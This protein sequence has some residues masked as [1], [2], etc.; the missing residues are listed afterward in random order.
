MGP[1]VMP[2]V[3]YVPVSF[4]PYSNKFNILCK[5][6]VHLQYCWQIKCFTTNHLCPYGTIM[7]Y[8]LVVKKLLL[9]FVTL[10]P[11]ILICIENMNHT[12]LTTLLRV[13]VRCT[14][15]SRG[16]PCRILSIRTC[17]WID[18]R[19]FTFLFFIYQNFIILLKIIFGSTC[20]PFQF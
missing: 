12:T 8:L 5:M 11:S 3:S 15:L 14:L 20:C 18:Y 19:P 10:Y 16:V 6:R 1:F 2:P 9:R 17:S 13:G 4:A 7:S